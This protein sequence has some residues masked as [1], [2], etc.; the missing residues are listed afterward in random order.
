M[1]L[2]IISLLIVINISTSLNIIHNNLVTNYLVANHNL[3]HDWSFE[4][5]SFSTGKSRYW[6]QKLFYP[7]SNIG[8]LCSQE[9]VDHQRTTYPFIVSNCSNLIKDTPGPKTGKWFVWLSGNA[10]STTAGTIF[11]NFEMHYNTSGI[12]ELYLQIN[13]TNPNTYSWLYIFIDW[14]EALLR[15]GPENFKNYSSYTLIRTYVP[16]VLGT[17]RKLT[18]VYLSDPGNNNDITHYFIDDVS[19]W[20]SN[21]HIPSNS[22]STNQI[23][24]NLVII[25][26]AVGII[27]GLAI[28]LLMFLV[29]K[30]HRNYENYDRL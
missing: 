26:I 19:I 17:D 29:S 5:T 20:E 4:D 10:T 15:F 14:W 11:Q 30:C 13:T 1:I 9:Y 12:M 8:L 18:F 22:S 7:K 25:M 6:S 16:P 23:S 27:L 24:V 21:P 2:I 3:I 28:I